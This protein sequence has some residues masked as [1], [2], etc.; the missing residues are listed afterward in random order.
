VVGWPS[1]YGEI[2]IRGR[3]AAPITPTPDWEK[4]VSDRLGELALEP[5]EC[6]DVIEELAAH[7]DD[8][9][10]DLRRR[11][12]SQEVAICRCMSE[13]LDW[14][15]FRRKI[16]SAR[17]KEDIMTNRV[18]QLWLPGLV[19]FALSMVL[20]ALTEIFGPKPWTTWGHNHPVALFYIPWL[21]SL[22]FVG[23]LGAYLSQRAGGSRRAILFSTIFSILPFLATILVVIP[24]S[25]AFDH[26]VAHN[27]R[28]MA[29]LLFLFGWVFL[30]GVAL[31]IGGL[32][33][34]LFLSRRI[35]VG[36]VTG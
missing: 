21:L 19:T 28:P 30:P 6:A 32:P 33:T 20:L 34:Q 35:G 18:T 1:S 36:R 25:L 17:R 26:V 5:Q 9:F 16:Q 10:A 27:V 4:L 8:V 2:E 23:A 13:V 15:D 24:L 22:P 29:F 7:L 3:S 12:F 31:L 11:G 14:R